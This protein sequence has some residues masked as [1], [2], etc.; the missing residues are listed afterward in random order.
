MCSRPGQS[1]QTPAL[2]AHLLGLVDFDVCL[3]L[4]H[5]L[6]YEASGRRDGQITLLICEHPELITVGRSGSR[7][8]IHCE[9]KELVSQQI[10]V[11]WV[12]RGGGVV[13]HAP[14]QLAVY[15]IVPLEWHGYSVGEYLARLQSSILDT[16]VELGI[17]AQPRSGQHGL[18]GRSGQL[19]AVGTAVRSWTTYFGAY[20][21]VSPPMQLCRLVTSDPLSH[22]AVG[23]LVAE[24]QQL[25]KMTSVREAVLRHVTAALGCD[26]FHL[27]SGHPLWAEA[28]DTACESATRVG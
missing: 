16:L 14:G 13:M 24:R 25:V 23:G 21:N 11:R 1:R 18:W 2:Q 7:A 26:R 22:S 4:Q 28:Q 10:D 15:P 19:V 3:A 27:Y 17:A 6:V 20:I 5:R 9:P 12:N 8:H